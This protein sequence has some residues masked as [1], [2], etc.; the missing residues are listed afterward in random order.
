VLGLVAKHSKE[1]QDTHDIADFDAIAFF[2]LS[3]HPVENSQS[4]LKVH[5]ILDDRV[6]SF[7]RSF[8][9]YE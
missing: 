3:D 5:M 7:H 9:V 2:Q 4:S 6:G 1:L 8:Q